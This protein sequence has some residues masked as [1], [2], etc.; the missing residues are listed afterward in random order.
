V[1]A[2]GEKE[3]ILDNSIS[4]TQTNWHLTEEDF[5]IFILANERK[6]V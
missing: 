2:E 4:A 3:E 6:G 5:F 1:K